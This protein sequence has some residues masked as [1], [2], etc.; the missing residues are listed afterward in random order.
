MRSYGPAPRTPPAIPSSNTAIAE[1]YSTKRCVPD[2]TNIQVVDLNVELLEFQQHVSPPTLY[3]EGAPNSYISVAYRQDRLTWVHAY[4][5]LPDD[6]CDTDAVDGRSNDARPRNVVLDANLHLLRLFVQNPKFTL[7][8]F[9][10]QGFEYCKLHRGVYAPAIDAF[11]EAIGM[12]PATA[13]S[14]IP[15]CVDEKFRSMF[16]DVEDTF[17]AVFAQP[18]RPIMLDQAYETAFKYHT[19]AFPISEDCLIYY[20]KH[21]RYTYGASPTSDI[22]QPGSP[23]IGKALKK[24]E[25]S[26]KVVQRLTIRAMYTLILGTWLLR[27]YH[28]DVSKKLIHDRIIASF[29]AML[30]DEDEDMMDPK[31]FRIFLQRDEILCAHGWA[32]KIF[33]GPVVL[34]AAAA[35]IKLP[36]HCSWRLFEAIRPDAKDRVYK[37]YDAI[38]DALQRTAAWEPI[39]AWA[40]FLSLPEWPADAARLAA[41]V[42]RDMIT[43]RRVTFDPD[44]GAFTAKSKPM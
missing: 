32:E 13:Y 2:V 27:Y 25:T 28:V 33:Q 30:V 11:V 23:A 29:K 15:Y 16:P 39:S 40:R 5:A 6:R 38:V 18:R 10:K 7:A 35:A 19:H 22:P 44:A 36:D 3:V 43:A 24:P 34:P 41:H 1:M 17:R 20:Y 9:T 4:A 42:V 31:Q 26:E 12:R 37:S 14:A 8:C 21:T